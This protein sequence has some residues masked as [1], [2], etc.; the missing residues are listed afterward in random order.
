[1]LFT[2]SAHKVTVRHRIPVF[3]PIPRISTMGCF[4]SRPSPPEQISMSTRPVARTATPIQAAPEMPPAQIS[5]TPSQ[6]RSRRGSTTSIHSTKS[7]HGSTRHRA[8]SAPQRVHSL[9]SQ[10]RNR[11]K[12]LGV[13]SGTS[14]VNRSG[15][16]LSTPGKS[17]AQLTVLNTR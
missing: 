7:Q 5:R 12:T 10:D 4:A 3:S 14:R 9:S 6:S 16:R 2:E 1:M 15:P 13:P 17:N 11:A 8:E